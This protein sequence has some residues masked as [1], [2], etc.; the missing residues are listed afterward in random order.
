MLEKNL[1]RT[2]KEKKQSVKTTKRQVRLLDVRSDLV[3]K[4]IKL[5]TL[6]SV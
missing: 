3:F 5:N 2:K 6:L 4:R 1:S